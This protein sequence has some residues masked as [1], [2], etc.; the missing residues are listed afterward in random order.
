MKLGKFWCSGSTKKEE[1][2]IGQ[3][4]QNNQ[5]SWD[6]VHQAN[7]TAM[8]EADGIGRSLRRQEIKKHIQH[9]LRFSLL[10]LAGSSSPS[11]GRRVAHSQCGWESSLLGLSGR[12]RLIQSKVC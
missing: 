4:P 11:G 10:P 3:H 7:P 6:T 1:L 12:L 8:H 9:L 5:E 2:S